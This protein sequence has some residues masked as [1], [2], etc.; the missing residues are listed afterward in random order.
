METVDYEWS[1]KWYESVNR[2]QQ[3]KEVKMPRKDENIRKRKDGPLGSALY[4]G[5]DMDGKIRYGYLYGKSYKEVKD[6]KIKVIHNDRTFLSGIWKSAA[7]L[8]EDDRIR[9]VS[10]Q[11]RNHI[12]Y[13]IKVSTYQ[14]R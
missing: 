10:V 2:I 14:I 7:V 4:E 12:R 6:K 9:T 5:R 1:K 3:I 13:T 11:W 8:L